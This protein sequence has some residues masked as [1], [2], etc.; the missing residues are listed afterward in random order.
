MSK[1]LSKKRNMRCLNRE[2]SHIQSAT[3]VRHQA[4]FFVV[5]KRKYHDYI[6]QLVLLII[7]PRMVRDR[8]TLY[9][10]IRNTAYCKCAQARNTN[11]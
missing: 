11:S 4:T 3:N 7:A 9:V 1:F 6:N 5:H 10:Y 2:I 8:S